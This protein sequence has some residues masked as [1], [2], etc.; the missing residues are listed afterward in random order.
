MQEHW[1]ITDNKLFLNSTLYFPERIFSP[2]KHLKQTTHFQI[3][4]NDISGMI[5]F[6]SDIS[7]WYFPNDIFYIWFLNFFLAC[8]R[9]IMLY[10]PNNV[11]KGGQT[12]GETLIRIGEIYQ[13]ISL[14]TINTAGKIKQVIFQVQK[15][16]IYCI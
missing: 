10:F 1:S 9:A 5:F 16:D 11:F 14:K 3:F 13:F 2:R 15:W 7:Q 12:F 4:P 8:S 6:L